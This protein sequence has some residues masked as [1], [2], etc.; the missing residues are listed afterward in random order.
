MICQIE[1]PEIWLHKCDCNEAVNE[2]LIKIL[3]N[4]LINFSC[5]SKTKNIMVAICWLPS[6]F[7]LEES[8]SRGNLHT[9]MRHD[10][11]QQDTNKVKVEP[12][13]LRVQL[14]SL[15]NIKE[16]LAAMNTAIEDLDEEVGNLKMV[17]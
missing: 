7:T 9:T 17:S 5:A 3:L 4:Y 11:W 8:H 13:A 14:S 12:C 10:Q 1:E 2:M 15:T 6:W 16:V